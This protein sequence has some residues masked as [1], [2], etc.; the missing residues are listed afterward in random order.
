[1]PTK[2]ARGRPPLDTRT[3][4][5]DAVIGATVHC[6]LN[7]GFSLR[8]GSVKVDG[9]PGVAEVVGQLA[10]V[11]LGRASTQGGA[12]S[13]R[14]VKRIYEE[15]LGEGWGSLAKL[16]RETRSQARYGV[17]WRRRWIP[18]RGA[19]L[20]SLATKLL[21][22]GGK[23]P[24]DESEPKQDGWLYADAPKIQACPVAYDVSQGE[25]EDS[26]LILNGKRGRGWTT[27][28]PGKV[29]KE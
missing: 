20:D 13:E 1:M 5:L 2:R 17:A 29:P 12:L 14:Q 11:V 18:Q 24:K 27:A 19:S 21:R 23:W 4:R 7:W 10:P 8:R 22:N 26:V 25:G 15:W 16:R 6:L 3:R 9:E 28:P